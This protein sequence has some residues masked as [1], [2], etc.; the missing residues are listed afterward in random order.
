MLALAVAAVPRR[1]VAAACT[2]RRRNRPR[3][4]EQVREEGRMLAG[5]LDGLHE[6]QPVEVFAVVLL[7][8]TEPPTRCV[9]TL[10][11]QRGDT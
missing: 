10:F 4:V 1:P 8:L 9:L 6:V 11:D 2:D 7:R 3:V 5:E